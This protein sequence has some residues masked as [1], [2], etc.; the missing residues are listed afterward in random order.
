MRVLLIA[1][2]PFYSERGT[3]IAV[4][5]LAET[6][7]EAGHRVDVLT[8]SLGEDIRIDGLKIYR[9]AKIPGIHNVGIGFSLRKVCLDAV[10][11]VRLFFLARP[12]R[13]GVVHAVEEA[14]YPALALRW[15]HR[16]PVVYDMDSSLAGQLSQGVFR[17][18]LSSRVLAGLEEWALARAD[19]VIAVCE[20][21]GERARKVRSGDTVHVIP[22]I[23]V[24]R[25]DESDCV[26]VL[27]KQSG[28]GSLI[29]L[30]VGNLEPYQG[31][32]LLIEAAHNL[33][34]ECCLSILV[35]GGTSRDVEVYKEK[36][37]ERGLYG[38]VIFL[39]QRPLGQLGGLLRQADILLSPRV[40]GEN[41]PLKIFS[42]MDAGIPIVATDLRTHTQVLDVDTAFLA[43]PTPSS[44][45]QAMSVLAKDA[46]MRRRL[47]AAAR[48]KVREEYSLQAFRRKLADVYDRLQTLPCEGDS[49]TELERGK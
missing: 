38:R 5:L 33:P 40:E 8:Y 22:D 30:Y 31:I 49:V 41:T 11:C 36:V 9:C 21:L 20:A 17:S 46:A 23:P 3:P 4:R 32:D 43:A 29:A 27:A 16:A 18:N 37:R 1:P 28:P 12:G 2:Q 13:Y 45:A 10:L 19:Q 15:R 44:F 26:E 6:L 25:G 14:V 35:V 42:Y 7:C 47:G 48:K 34:E 39:G 24:S